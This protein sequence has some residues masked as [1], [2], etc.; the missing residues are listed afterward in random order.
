MSTAP[1]A[2]LLDSARAALDRHD[3]QGAFDVLSA[4]D[5]DG[6]LTGAE[7]ELLAEAA[8]WTGQLPLAMDAR[9]RAYAKAAKSGEV[10]VAVLAALGLAR[11]N[12]FRMAPEVAIG[13]IRRAER[14][15][16]GLEETPQH[17][18]L[19][20]TRAF[21]AALI[22]DNEES[23]AQASRAL[24]VARR[25]GD[26]GVE[27]IAMSAKA[28]ALLARGDVEEG[29][30]LAD[31]ATLTAVSGELE[32][33]AA[34]GVC[35]TTIESCA[36]IGDL[37]RA[38]EWT[39]AQD[40]WCRREGISGFPGMCRLFRSEIKTLHGAWLEA[41][42]EARAASAELL[43]FMPG[44]AGMGHYQVGEIRLRRGDLPAAEEALLQAHA[45]GQDTE[46]ALSSLRLAQGRV[47]A[48]VRGI[49]LALDEPHRR[50]SW[51]APPNSQMY[52][53]RLLPAQ[54]EIAIAAG[55]LATARAA[56]DEAAALAERFGT[57][58]VRAK[59]A[60][61]MGAVQLAEGDAD[62]AAR[63]LREA[64]G[65]WV[66]LDAPY[67]TARA[68][69]LLADAY[70]ATGAGDP[71]AVELRTARDAFERLGAQ[72]DLRR[73]EEA[74]KG[75]AGATAAA[76]MGTAT[77]RTVRAFMFTDIVDSTRLAETLGDEAWDR[78]IRWHD[79]ALR[80]AAAEHG[81]ED[82]KA[83]G[84]GFFMAFADAD[85]AIAAAIAIQRRFR[86]QRDVQGFAPAVRIGV[87][88]AEANRVGL[89][90]TGIG[91]NQAARIG[92][93]AEAG[94][95]LASRA[96]LGAARRS[97]ATGEPRVLELKGLSEPVEV[98]SVDW[99]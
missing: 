28:A 63:T 86:D 43:G 75:I 26:P 85:Q 38:S 81:G 58:P 62:T 59:A 44:A 78:L 8:W 49:Q 21:H 71:A 88:Q 61:C 6:R 67:E 18:F 5:T 74:L 29:L 1:D 82:V 46:P 47:D 9:E 33:A 10:P 54:V 30:A 34:G 20:V 7:L 60:F 4:A 91:V 16:Q 68:R 57:L 94:E 13:W 12:L 24:D 31:E 79:Q 22:G 55:D 42:A 27:A 41:E 89:D 48:A 72:L 87:H 3:W 64:V 83:T 97:F 65:L 37:R 56:A 80:A 95:I 73:A 98:V 40:R 84:D 50:P 70:R 52:R 77:V 32:P 36:G 11:D 25:L 17:A 23:L 66:E 99:R 2:S 45:L 15:L 51:W 39:E 92:A 53:L 93:A 69:L 96:T 19:G 76:P 14:L 90:Y 35:C